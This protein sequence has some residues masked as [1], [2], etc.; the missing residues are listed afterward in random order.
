MAEEKPSQPLSTSHPHSHF[1]IFFQKYPKIVFKCSSRS[2]KHLLVL[3]S[4]QKSEISSK[5]HST[6]SLA[7]PHILPGA[8]ILSSHEVFFKCLFTSPLHLTHTPPPPY[9]TSSPSPP[10]PKR[11]MAIENIFS[12]DS[13]LYHRNSIH[14]YMPFWP[15]TRCDSSFDSNND[16]DLVGQSLP[17]GPNPGISAAG[18]C[19]SSALQPV[20]TS[21]TYP[22]RYHLCH[23]TFPTSQTRYLSPSLYATYHTFSMVLQLSVSIMLFSIPR[24]HYFHTFPL[25]LSIT[26]RSTPS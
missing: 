8:E 20:P 1:Q 14:H 12:R 19:S 11:A 23:G 24:L 25:N 17:L 18:C 15:F 3:I 21:T 2:R 22:P 7:L 9:P 6:S 10:S 13:F 26:F 4:L 16:H 5:Y